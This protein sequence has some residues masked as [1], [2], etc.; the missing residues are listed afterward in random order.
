MKKFEYEFYGRESELQ[1]LLTSFDDIVIKKKKCLTYLIQGREGIGKTRLITEFI[2][3]INS[4]IG[5]RSDIPKFDLKKNVISYTYD[6]KSNVPYSALQEIKQKI[7]EREKFFRIISSFFSILLAIPIIGVNDLIE[8]GKKFWRNIKGGI[9]DSEIEKSKQDI[10]IFNKYKK[11]LRKKSRKAPLIIFI[12]NVQWIDKLS[13]DLIERLLS[14]EKSI[15]GMIILEENT[16][17]EFDE[18]IQ[19]RMTVMVNNKLI[20]SLQLIGLANDFPA[21]LLKSRFGEDFFS[22]EENDILYVI[23]EGCPGNLINFIEDCIKEEPPWLY[24]KNSKWYKHPDFKELIKPKYQRLLELII[25][26]LEDKEITDAELKIIN[27]FSRLWG[28]PPRTVNN[29]ILMIHDIRFAGFKILGKLGRGIVGNISLIVVD[30][31]N[32]RYIVEYLLSSKNQN[33]I[34]FNKIYFNN[35]YLWMAKS[36]KNCENG[37]LIIWDYL[38]GKKTREN[39]IALNEENLKKNIDK[40]V[41]V[42]NGLKELHKKGLYHGFIRPQAIIEIED[43]SYK[44][45]VVNPNL[46]DYL[47]LKQYDNFVINELNYLSPEQLN[48]QKPDSRSDIYSLGVIFYKSLVGHYPYYGIHREDLIKSIKYNHLNFE[49]NLIAHI[50]DEYQKILRKC[51]AFDPNKRYQSAEE[52]LKELPKKIPHLYKYCYEPECL[53]GEVKEYIAKSIKEIGTEELLSSIKKKFNL[54]TNKYVLEQFMP[55]PKPYLLYGLLSLLILLLFS[56]YFNL[57]S[58]HSSPSVK[59]S[60]EIVLNVQSSISNYYTTALENDL[61]SGMIFNM[62]KDELDLNSS[63]II[64]SQSE[65]NYRYPTNDS[66]KYQPKLKVNIHLRARNKQGIITVK[67]SNGTEAEMFSF[68]NSSELLTGIVQNIA[69][70]ILGAKLKKSFFTE[71]VD[72][73]HAYYQGKLAWE[74]LDVTRALNKFE[75]A[76]AIDPAFI[77]AKLRLVE[78]Y[79]WNGMTE[80]A[81][82]KLKEVL[83]QLKRLSKIDSLNARALEKQL[84]GDLRGAINIS[85]KIIALQPTKKESPYRVAELYYQLCDINKAKKFY[86][87]VLDIDSLFTPAIN[88][89]GYCYIHLGKHKLALEKFQKYAHL[90][91]SANSYDSWGD[92][93]FAAGLLDSAEWAKKMGLSIDPDLNYLYSSLAYIN[94]RQGKLRKALKNINEYIKKSGTSLQFKSISYFLKAFVYYRQKQFSKALDTCLVAKQ[95]FDSQDIVSRNHDMHWLLGILYFKNNL[96]DKVKNEINEFNNLIKIYK[97]NV[98]NYHKI[99]KYKLHLQAL[100]AFREGDLNKLNK[101]V[102]KFNN[103]SQLKFKIKDHGSPFG[104]AYFNTSFGKMYLELNKISVAKNLF[105]DALKYSNSYPFAHYYLYKSYLQVNDYENAK[106]EKTIL[107]R[108]WNKADSSFKLIY[109]L[110]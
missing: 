60:R 53:P 9:Q 23:S 110:N 41:Q 39:F 6:Q 102:L 20:K 90:D 30:E 10:K 64:L 103:S 56:L 67:Y 22:G 63:E 34:I 66:I 26:A 99:L 98:T 44:L 97:I 89:L 12:Q 50:P 11:F 78:I 42:A 2:K 79:R 58:E 4:N 68:V 38:E 62:L 25:Q 86:L 21:K 29:T 18:A 55:R 43:G 37:I 57:F 87:D 81:K 95:I 82:D 71:D 83:P 74:K 91:K 106:V 61:S 85:K 32:K 77:L 94:I 96:I 31:E 27:D 47:N 45:A 109:G 93:Y 15:W 88:H 80:K 14:T 40:I 69:Q 33:K 101:I 35:K 104:P 92:G 3:N 19:Q 75:E 13:L 84:N 48:G 59:Y 73:Y 65:Y 52:L 100:L 28:I 108:I 49:G 5:L 8:A 24:I 105:N 72:A 1:E 17:E 36:V 54:I 7:I 76:L 70:K 51:L 107:D 16:S 46:I